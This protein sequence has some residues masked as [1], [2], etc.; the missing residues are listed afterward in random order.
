MIKLTKIALEDIE[1]IP[2]WIAFDNLP[3][4]AKIKRRLLDSCRRLGKFPE[5][6]HLGVR[7]GTREWSCPPWIIVY[8]LQGK[9]VIVLEVRDSRQNR[10]GHIT[11]DDLD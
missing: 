9:N 8:L 2:A 6:G 3:I 7:P 1:N 5:I 10:S 11:E 4:A